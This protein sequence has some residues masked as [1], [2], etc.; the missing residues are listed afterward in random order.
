LQDFDRPVDTIKMQRCGGDS[1]TSHWIEFV[2]AFIIK[3]G[4]NMLTGRSLRSSGLYV[5]NF[6]AAN[7][8]V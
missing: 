4:T 3:G 7:Y 8:D 6:K 5:V 1:A 2:Q